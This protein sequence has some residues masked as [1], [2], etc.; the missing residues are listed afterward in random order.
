MKK[1]A[2]YLATAGL[3]LG[4]FTQ[5]HSRGPNA[6]RA[7]KTA[8]ETFGRSALININNMAMWFERNGSSGYNPLTSGAGVTFPRST[9]RV[10]YRDGLVWGG[11]VK[12][13]DPQ[14]LRV[15]GQ[16]YA[17]G[18][19][20]GR[21]VSKGE[22]EDPSD[23]SVRIYRIRRD[24]QTA[25]LRLDA[26]ESL[27][28]G[29]SAVTDSDVEA[30]RA[31]YEQD[32]R[33]WPYQ[34][35]APY[36]DNDGDGEYNPDTDEPGVA[37]ADQVAWFVIN[38]LDVGA[39]QSLYGSKP[40]GL[41][42]QVL[43]WGY[44]RTDALGDVIFKKFTV[45]YK[46]TSATPDT[47]RIEDMYFAQWADPDLGNY[48]DDFAGADVDLSLGY[49]YNSINTDSRYA[50][51]GLAPPAVGY[52]FLQGPAVPV[53][54]KGENGDPLLDEDGNFVLDESSEAIF[55][56]GRRPGYRNLPMTSFVYFAAGSAIDDPELGEY[57][58]T[59]EWY[60]LLRGFQPQPD[61]SNPVPYTNPLTGD[62]TFFTLDGDPTTAQGWND[63]VP[64]PAGDRRIVLNTGPFEM[65][66]GDTQEV[67]VALLGGIS[68]DRLRSVSSLKFNDQFVQ[69]AYNSFFAVPKP[70]AQPNARVIELDQT[71]I[72]D[73][74]WDDE[75]IQATEG[76]GS[77][78]FDFE[79]YNLYQLPSAEATLS[80]GVKVATFD[81]ENGVTTILGIALDEESGVVLDVPLQVGTDFGVKR[82]IRIT[83]DHIRSGPLVNGQRYYFAVTAYNRATA[84]G[85]ATTTLESTPQ[86][87]ICVPQEPPLGT[88]YLS[89]PGDVISAE[90]T[91]GVSDG[92]VSVSVVDP[93]S[94]TGHEYAVE[95][96]ADADGNTVWN[97][98][99]KTSSQTLL[100]DQ[101]DQTG[102]AFYIGSAGI[103]VSVAG[104]PAGMKSWAG[105]A[106]PFEAWQAS[107]EAADLTG[108]GQINAADFAQ[109][110]DHASD[111]RWFTWAGGSEDWGA[112]GFEGAITGD[113]NHQW[114][115]P[116]TVTPDRLRTVELRFTDV[117][118]EDGEDQYKPVDV[119]NENVSWAYRYLRAAG[120]DPP[121]L[122]DLT[123][124]QNPWDFGKYIINTEGPGVYVYQ[125]RNP[126]ALSAWD[127]ESEPPRRLE[128]A[129]L[130]NNQSGG[131]VNG[132]YGPP[133]YNVESN[134]AGPGPREWLFIFDLDYTDPNQGENSDILLNNGLI[135]DGTEGEEHLP[136]MWIVFAERRR[137]DDF[138]SD[139]DS[140]LLV[141]NHVNTPADRFS[142]TVQGSESSDAYLAEDIEKINVFPNP[143][144]GVNAA[145]TSRYSHFVT[146]S[147][148]PPKAN[149]RIFDMSGTLVRTIEKDDPSQFT[150][151]DLQNHNALP[152]ASG[153][154]IAHIELP[155]HGKSR[156]LKLAII[157]EQQFLENL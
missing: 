72:L 81:I 34:K 4:A 37:G 77:P 155:D 127:I 76:E 79:G 90:H 101:T 54:Q 119:N 11:I 32:W 75:S 71:I 20:P 64:L 114:F 95:Y 50:P 83:Q 17:I 58:G 123:T 30:L 44:A 122:D 67:V 146:F 94:T 152:V 105:P 147:H 14:E 27:G 149:I 48:G 132:V 43:L 18:T 129:F 139:G 1:F 55:N 51:F 131:L 118:E 115:A 148:L 61:I 16:T 111:T 60:N 124:T 144:L 150:R 88:R 47:A 66:L 62:D 31:Q 103:E 133:W 52:D 120:A 99:D 154:Y 10:I 38:D 130:E 36:Y 142:F 134:I 126:I 65:A 121:A 73:W 70:P 100:A 112:E 69:D 28:I 140:F 108:D 102:T 92:T 125:E 23:P 156:I 80:Q 138:P 9:D 98:V 57:I 29:L 89:E 42:V 53:F 2:I 7:A 49:V 56:F 46:G 91:A 86:N 141:A 24:Y 117:S 78:G 22:A 40:V 21:I 110:V 106:M 8:Q 45:I 59:E 19:V 15:G 96:A 116:T 41:E 87:L 157:Q 109:A 3:L 151:W 136:F 135:Y 84:E 26:S 137:E 13:G 85:A 153:M 35:G 12:D 93:T 113:P 25:D 5:A 74:G 63:G 68:T 6:H 97:L 104:P 128:V 82:N 107:P 145:E 39:A 143:Y 33:E